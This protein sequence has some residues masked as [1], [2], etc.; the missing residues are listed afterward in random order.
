M[1]STLTSKSE[2]TKIAKFSL[3]YTWTI[4]D[5]MTYINH[6]KLGFFLQSA[7]FTDTE[8][9]MK[10]RILFYPCG[11][12][13][14]STR[15]FDHYIAACVQSQNITGVNWKGEAYVDYTI[16]I[17]GFNKRIC[18][19]SYIYDTLVFSKS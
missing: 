18:Y 1:Q 11:I 7:E 5:A 12:K 14:S 16:T 13:A 3:E 9:D 4:N 10:F 19:N 8:H 15:S 17:K 2:I 6:K